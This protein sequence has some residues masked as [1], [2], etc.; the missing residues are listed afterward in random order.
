MLHVVPPPAQ[1]CLPVALSELVEEARAR[2]DALA[3]AA[4]LAVIPEGAVPAALA[5]AQA[6]AQLD[7][8]AVVLARL[9][10]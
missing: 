2:L 4:C 3:E 5:V 6:R 1:P 8:A 9:A 7:A 10:R